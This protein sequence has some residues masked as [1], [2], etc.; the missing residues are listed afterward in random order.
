[1][2]T[3][4][5]IDGHAYLHLRNQRVACVNLANGEKT[6]ETKKKFGKYWSLIAR[7]NR[8]LALDQKGE[9]YHLRANPEKFDVI[10]ERKI[11]KGNTWGHIA[12][13]G[14]KVIIRELEALTVFDWN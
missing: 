1:M 14:S 4:V 13:S 5:V 6:W 11:A 12:V 9:L 2:S 7:G 3:P 8:I 10:S